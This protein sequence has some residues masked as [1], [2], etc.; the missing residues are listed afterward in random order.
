MAQRTPG[1]LVDH[2]SVFRPHG[3]PPF[4]PDRRFALRRPVKLQCYLR[5][6]GSSPF[7]MDVVEL[8]RAGFRAETIFRL[9]P[10]HTVW[11]TIPAFAALESQVVWRKNSLYGCRFHHPLHEAVFDHVVNLTNAGR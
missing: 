2:D 10:G 8:S 9:S 6:P 7:V 4:E 1:S 3:T 11:L 5:E